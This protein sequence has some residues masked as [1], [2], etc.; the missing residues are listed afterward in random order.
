MRSSPSGQVNPHYLLT[1]PAGQT[2]NPSNSWGSLTPVFGK[3]G[4]NVIVNWAA[5]SYGPRGPLQLEAVVTS[6]NGQVLVYAWNWT[7][8]PFGPTG[9]DLHIEV[10]LIPKE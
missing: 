3:I 1:L 9:L 8:A 4:D 7:A 6:P 2:I 5:D 10:Q